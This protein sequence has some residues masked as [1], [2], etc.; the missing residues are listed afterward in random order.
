MNAY[1]IPGLK[2]V[3]IPSTIFKPIRI[4]STEEIMNIICEECGTD[5]PQM[6][7]RRRDRYIVEARQILSY[8][9]VKKVRATL[10]YVGSYVL[11]GRDHTTIIHSIRKFEALYETDDAFREK[12]DRIFNKLTI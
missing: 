11:G 10:D 3:K 5:I 4:H 1:A 8:V 2:G 12:A 7:G 9:M 6:R